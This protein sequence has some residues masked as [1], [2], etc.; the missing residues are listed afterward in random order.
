ML[1]KY[2][3]SNYKSIGGK[4]KFSMFPTED[5]VEGRYLTT[6]STKMGDWKILRRGGLFGPNASGKSNFIQSL[7]FARD[8]V[9]EGRKSG[10]STNVNPF[11]G[12]VNRLTTFQFMI[13][14][15]GEVYDYGFAL[16]RKMIH[17]E[18]LSILDE[19]GFQD[20]YN[21]TTSETGETNIV[22]TSAFGEEDSKQR[23]LVEVL[24]ESIQKNQKNQ[25]FLNKLFDNGVRSIEG[26]AHWFEN[27]TVVYPNM[28]VNA[29][30]IAIKRNE[31]FREYLSKELNKL[32]TGV[33]D[34]STDSKK[35]NL[36]ELAEKIKIPEEMI[37]KIESD[38]RGVIEL[39][40]KYY[41]FT[42]EDNDIAMIQLKF[43][44][45]LGEQRID[46]DIEDESDGTKRLLDLLPILFQVVHGSENV[47]FVDELDRSLHTKLSRYILDEFIK[48]SEDCL[49]QIIYTAHD[50]NLIN[51]E[52][53]REEE[54]SFI[55]KNGIGESKIKPLSDF[56]IKEGQ[57][58]LKDYLNGRFGAVPFIRRNYDE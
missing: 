50:V 38:Q 31:D 39:Y 57:N 48:Q 53:F 41:I 46:F 43:V 34:I 25:L 28:K 44:H 37:Q 15:E 52:D 56:D 58:L 17:S 54:I 6:I 30:P 13:Y 21:R 19:N 36:R 5:H 29:L 18:W 3:V 7:E 8:Y 40:G 35:I 51:L 45:Q 16:D 10:T 27:V 20:M 24:K 33:L 22:I 32:D 11:K 55:D 47:Y 9:V 12:E 1:L 4:L 23:M 2:V 14:T 26:I 42:D 49:S